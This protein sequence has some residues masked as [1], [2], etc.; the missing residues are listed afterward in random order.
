MN[1]NN[2]YKTEKIAFPLLFIAT[3]L[4]ILPVIF[5]VFII[6]QKGGR[7]ISWEFL[8][9]MPKM[10]MRE[11]GI[12]PAIVGTIYLVLGT[13]VFALPL[14]VLS[15]IYLTEYAKENMLTRLIKL[16]IINLACV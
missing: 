14:G 4:V 7:A 1:K 15:A 3:V 16:A 9:A 2:A 12:F 11:G 5:I 6:I 13:L 10:G 8:T